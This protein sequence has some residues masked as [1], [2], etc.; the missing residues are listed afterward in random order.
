MSK[1]TL[2]KIDTAIATAA[3]TAKKANEQFHDA[4][5]MIFRHAAPEAVNADCQGSGDCTRAVK[6]VRAMP[7]SFR[8]TMMIEWFKQNTPI[9]IV[10]RDTGDKCEFDPAYKKLS[11]E[12]KLAHW[13]IENANTVPFWELAE[14][15]PEQEPKSFEDLV[16][17]FTQ[18]GKR[19][20]KMVEDGKVKDSDADSAL[21][22]A[23]KVEGITFKRVKATN[24]DDKAVVE[25]SE[26]KAVA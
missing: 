3:T 4:A 2:K 21:A 16:K 6:L 15:N 7:A 19:I 23:K 5:M 13:N 24:D 22:M 26:D 11:A 20:T 14:A 1:I 17:M 18:M 10:L 8:R 12:E 9:R 25:E